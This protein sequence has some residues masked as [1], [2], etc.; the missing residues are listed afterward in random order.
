MPKITEKPC[1]K[2]KQIKPIKMFRKSPKYK[3]GYR[4]WCNDC[5]SHGSMEYYKKNR[6]EIISFR[7]N[8]VIQTTR[9]GNRQDRI[10]IMGIIKQPYPIDSVCEICQKS[11]NRLGYHHW[12]DNNPSCG[13]WACYSCHSGCNFLEKPNFVTKY[14]ELKNS[15]NESY[16][17]DTSVAPMGIGKKRNTATSRAIR[18][19]YFK[20]PE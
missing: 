15:I 12:D 18:R 16:K 20:S 7:R 10:F 3:S 5:E 9:T 6:A 19:H 14:I 8:H 4:S 2:C 11:S 1:P 17:P 13:I